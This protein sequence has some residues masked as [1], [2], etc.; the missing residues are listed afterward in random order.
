MGEKLVKYGSVKADAPN[1]INYGR[2]ATASEECLARTIAHELRHARA[3]LGKG[4]R[5]NNSEY[6]FLRAE[7]A[8][9]RYMRGKR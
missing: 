8:L 1:V 3:Y 7:A 9:G 4:M 6:Q 2:A 5:G